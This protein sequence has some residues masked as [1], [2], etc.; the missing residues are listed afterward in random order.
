MKYT[1]PHCGTVIK[2]FD[3]KCTLDLTGSIASL[4]ESEPDKKCQIR[5]YERLK[6][7]GGFYPEVNCRKKKHK[8]SFQKEIICSQL[9]DLGKERTF[10][11]L[12]K[13]IKT[14]KNKL[15][16]Y[17]SSIDFELEGDCYVENRI[18]RR[19]YYSYIERRENRRIYRCCPCCKET[20]PE[21]AG[22]CANRTIVIIDPMF[23]A[24]K[25][26]MEK[27]FNDN[28]Y[29]I[30]GNGDS[31]TIF[32]R[33]KYDERVLLSVAV[34]DGRVFL[35]PR[36]D[37][38]KEQKRLQQIITNADYI[39]LILKKEGG[40]FSRYRNAIYARS[41]CLKN[42]RGIIG[43]PAEEDLLTCSKDDGD[44]KYIFALHQQSFKARCW[45]D[46]IDKSFLKALDL[47]FNDKY[48]Y[49]EHDT[50]AKVEATFDWV[51]YL[52]GI[53]TII[54]H[55]DKKIKKIRLHNYP[56]CWRSEEEEKYFHN[57]TNQSYFII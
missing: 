26:I 49:F 1:C 44:E 38:D 57:L 29:C 2:D 22:Q 20:V 46:Q 11:N 53:E 33:E 35:L 13:L 52:E 37:S 41:D 5:L 3:K 15:S 34:I 50:R 51:E 42:K 39:W 31:Y 56:L 17:G 6:K 9:D 18:G 27:Y 43:C 23:E 10:N 32:F 47:T 7:V 21:H 19:R 45:I 16:G 25:E 4:F 30:E 55:D 14:A 54:L 12:E 24:R 48:F 28:K 8:V 36:D 40:D